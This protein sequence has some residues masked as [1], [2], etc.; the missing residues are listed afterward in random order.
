MYFV[1]LTSSQIYLSTFNASTE[2][3]VAEG[4]H[5]QEE[6]YA[7]GL[8]VLLTLLCL[9]VAASL[10]V[11]VAARRDTT[12][13]EG[14]RFYSRSSHG[15]IV[16]LPRRVRFQLPE[17]HVNLGFSKTLL[18]SPTTDKENENESENENQDQEEGTITIC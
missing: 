11:C 13:L 14:L 1:T 9:G 10:L 3:G 12:L 15:D 5:L 16:K 18:L 17:S 4:P 8:T 6:K 7:T 2:E